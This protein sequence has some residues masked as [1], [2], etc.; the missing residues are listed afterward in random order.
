MRRA[1]PSQSSPFGREFQKIL[2]LLKGIE[3]LYVDEFVEND[4]KVDPK[5]ASRRSYQILVRCRTIESKSII[6]IAVSLNDGGKSKGSS[7]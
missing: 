3:E 6:H 5:G 4:G 2:W 1:K 7:T